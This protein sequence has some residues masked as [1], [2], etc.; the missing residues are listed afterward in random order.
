MEFGDKIYQFRKERGLSQEKFAEQLGVTKQA[1]QKWELGK[2]QPETS[3]LVKLAKF[4]NI[5]IDSLLLGSDIRTFEEM[6]DYKNVEPDYVARHQWEAYSKVLDVE[7][8]QSIEEGLEIEP[9]ADVMKSIQRMPDCKEKEQMADSVFSIVSSLKTKKDYPYDEPSDLDG[10]RS[11]RKEY[12]FEK[13]EFTEDALR[14]KISGAWNARIA[15]C[16][17]GK[18]V[19]GMRTDELVP[20]LKETGN[21]PMYRYIRKSDMNDAIYDKYKFRLRGRCYADAIECAPVDDDTNYTVMSQK[22][23]HDF[24]REFTPADV[25]RTWIRCQS[26][27]AYCTAERVTFVNLVNGYRPPNTAV[28]KNPFREW[29]GAQI[30]TD[31]YGYINPGDPETAADMAW[32]DASISH[33]KNGIYGAIF[34]ASMIACAAVTDNVRDAILGGLAQIPE[35]SRLYE[36]V[37]K[38]V[39][40]YDEGATEKKCFDYIHECYDEHTQ[41]GWCHTIPNAMIVAASLLFGNKDYGKSVCMAVQTGFDTDCNGATVGSVLGMMNGIRSIP[42]EWLKPLNGKLDTSIFG[43]GTVSI[44]SLVENTLKDIQPCK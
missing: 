16:L 6:P 38:I 41:H 39:S 31:Y 8:T 17:L 13:K 44:D 28:Y 18:T 24:G 23:I 5:S 22:I 26:K 25:G 36:Y 33:V 43:V 7:Y 3:K 15:G 35:K 37:K 11:S 4:F 9:Y 12:V 32:R 20:M 1:V 29:I 2:S 40:M 10:I 30:R 42:D 27:D 14:E 19:E 34:S 21:Y